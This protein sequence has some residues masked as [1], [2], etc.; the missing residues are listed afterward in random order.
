M[1]LK[2]EAPRARPEQ[3]ERIGKALLEEKNV[4]RMIGDELYGKLQEEGF[5]NLYSAEGKP[6][7]S[8]VILAVVSV[9]QFMEKLADRQATESMRMRLNWKYA[10]HLPLAYSGFDYSVLSEFRD[11]LI[12]G[13]QRTVCSRI[14]FDQRTREAKKR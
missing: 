14:G 6:G 5:A 10:L 2:I 8:P 7:I 11:R 1:N 4:Y 12:A 13:E 9:F 3:T